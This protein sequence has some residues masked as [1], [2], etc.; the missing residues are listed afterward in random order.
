[1]TH[2]VVQVFREIASL[3]T[4]HQTLF[5]F[6]VLV[7]VLSIPRI[8]R[9][10]PAPP[11]ASFARRAWAGFLAVAWQ[12]AVRLSVTA[13]NRWGGSF[14]IPGMIDPA[15]TVDKAASCP[16]CGAMLM[17]NETS[18]CDSCVKQRTME[19]DEGVHAPPKEPDVPVRIQ[20]RQR[21]H[22]VPEITTQIDVRGLVDG[23]RDR[24]EPLDR[25]LRAWV[26]VR[27]KSP[28]LYARD[29]E[30]LGRA[31]DALK[32]GEDVVVVDL[33][34]VFEDARDEDDS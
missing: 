31:G 33:V 25:P 10:L 17:P 8:P 27:C 34:Y 20:S 19:L 26:K 29:E 7:A 30:V 22:S 18:L 13:W 1:M 24:R 5:A 16:R 3:P 12:I 2:D 28:G 32:L 23:T 11:G 15:L 9:P 14:K 4:A 21:L 6:V